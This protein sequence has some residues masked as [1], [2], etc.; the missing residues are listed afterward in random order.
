[1][2]VVALLARWPACNPLGTNAKAEGIAPRAVA[3]RT[4]CEGDTHE[5][6][7][8]TRSPGGCRIGTRGHFPHCRHGYRPEWGRPAGNSCPPG[9]DSGS[10]LSQRRASRR[11]DGARRRLSSPRSAGQAAVGGRRRDDHRGALRR[12]RATFGVAAGRPRR[13]LFQTGRR[14]ARL[15]QPEGRSRTVIVEHVSRGAR[16]VRIAVR[17]PSPADAQGGGRGRRPGAHCRCVAAFLLH[18]GGGRGDVFVGP[19]LS[20]SEPSAGG[21]H[22]PGTP[23]PGPRSGDA[24]GTGPIPFAGDML[25]ADR[26]RRQGATNPLAVSPAV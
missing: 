14:P 21:S 15:S 6:T 18:S 19:P 8:S 26:A 23:E 20:R 7:D 11:R 12:S 4:R 22:V 2:W 13:F 10:G 25:A 3:E 17:S 9:A 16:V 1:M 24:S 5:A